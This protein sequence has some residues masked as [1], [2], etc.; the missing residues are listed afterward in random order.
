MA[1]LYTSFQ[2]LLLLLGLNCRLTSGRERLQLM[3]DASSIASKNIIIQLTL[4]QPE[5]GVDTNIIE[6]IL[7]RV[8]IEF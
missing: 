8:N 1:L 5:I 6:K 2:I 7:L 4:Y 3:M